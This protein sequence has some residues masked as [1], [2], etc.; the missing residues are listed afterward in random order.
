MKVEEAILYLM[1]EKNGGMKA[2][3]VLQKEEYF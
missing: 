3:S 2:P 1:A